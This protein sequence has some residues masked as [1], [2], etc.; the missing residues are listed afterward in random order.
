MILCVAAAVISDQL[1]SGKLLRS[2]YSIK[3][4]LLIYRTEEQISPPQIY[5]KRRSFFRTGV[6]LSVSYLIHRPRKAGFLEHCR[7]GHPLLFRDLDV[8]G[9]RDVFEALFAD[10]VQVRALDDDLLHLLAAREGFFIDRQQLVSRD[11]DAG[12]LLAALERLFP[13]T[14]QGVR[15]L[16]PAQLRAAPEGLIPD[17]LQVFREGDQ[18]DLGVAGKRLVPDLGHR[19][20]RPAGGHRVREIQEGVGVLC[21]SRTGRRV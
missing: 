17:Q 2:Q 15:Q 12:Q 13:D 11:L 1:L 7:V 16:D 14:D 8:G 18:L 5:A 4:W 20:H 21:Q 9:V 10:V 6:C 3:A 19:V